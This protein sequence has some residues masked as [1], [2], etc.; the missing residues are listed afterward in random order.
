MSLVPPCPPAWPCP[1]LQVLAQDVANSLI[2]FSQRRNLH[3]KLAE[4]LEASHTIPPVPAAIIGFHFAESCKHV[5]GDE[6]RRA[7]K[8]V[9]YWEKAGLEAMEGIDHLPVN[10][11]GPPADGFEWLHGLL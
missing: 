3:F 4:A 6:W 8:A 11:S 5:E 2:P 1:S 10:K 7:M 9:E